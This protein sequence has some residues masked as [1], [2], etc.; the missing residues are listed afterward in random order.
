MHQ[1]L[2]LSPLLFIHMLGALS[3]ASSI[4]RFHGSFFFA[5]DLAV[6]ADSLKK[7]IAKLT[8]CKVQ[9]WHGGQRFECQHEEK[10]HDLWSRA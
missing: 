3:Y 2:V 8:I 7:C 10:A 4:L 9:G 5:D 1:G 6:I